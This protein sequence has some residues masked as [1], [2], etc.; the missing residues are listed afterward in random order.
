M[1]RVW[2]KIFHC[3][4]LTSWLIIHVPL[5]KCTSNSMVLRCR[6]SC[7]HLSISQSVSF[8]L[9]LPACHLERMNFCFQMLDFYTR[10]RRFHLC[11]PLSVD[12][13]LPFSS[14]KLILFI[15]A[16]ILRTHTWTR[17]KHSWLD[18]LGRQEVVNIRRVLR[19]IVLFPLVFNLKHERKIVLHHLCS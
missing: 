2:W 7:R 10:K 6:P 17:K 8:P 3:F 5:L 16:S 11:H 18:T 13:S 19:S 1:E 15:V 9:I 14:T 4:T 12:H